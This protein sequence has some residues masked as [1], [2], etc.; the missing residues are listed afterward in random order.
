MEEKEKMNKKLTFIAMFRALDCLYEE[1]PNET[2][3]EYLSDANPYIFTDRNSADPAVGAE[4]ANKWISS[5]LP[6][7]ISAIDAYSFVQ[8]YLQSYTPFSA[9]FDDISLSEWCDLC[10]IVIE[11][12]SNLA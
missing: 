8:D 11:E 4:F 12:E 7:D 9:V 5:G 6:E 10:D 1:S 2:M 3:R